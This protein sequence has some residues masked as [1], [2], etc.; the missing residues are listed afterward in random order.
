MFREVKFFMHNQTVILL[1][2]TKV[3]LVSKAIILDTNYFLNGNI[4]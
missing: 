2:Y 3:S 1:S 4:N